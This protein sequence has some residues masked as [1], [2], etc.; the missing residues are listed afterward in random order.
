M[1]ESI[2]KRVNFYMG[3][4]AIGVLFCLIV[5]ATNI[6]IKDLD[7]WLHLKM[8][9]LITRFGYVPDHD[10][11]SCS[12]AGKPWVNHEWLFQ[13]LA[14]Y[15]YSFGGA[16]GLITMQTIV[17]SLTFLLLLFLGYHRDKHLGL[18]FLL[19][20][21]LLVYEFRFTIRPDIFSLL[22]FVIFIYVLA[23]HIDKNWSV[24]ALLTTQILWSNVH[25]F[26]F[27]GPLIICV[28][29]FSETIKR[30]IRLP[31]EWNEVG[32]LTNEEFKRL[33][34]IF[35]I[36]ILACFINPLTFRG[37]WYPI[38]VLLQF[39]HGSQ[40]FFE[41]I[42]ELQ[43]PI[44][45]NWNNIFS[46]NYSYY[47]L[48]IF[49][50]FISFI[51]NRK[52][53]DVG[54][55]FIWTVFLLFSLVAVRNV[56]YFALVAYLVTI[57]NFMSI[58]LDELIPIRFTDRKFLYMTSILFHLLLISWILDY[59][60]KMSERGYYDFDNYQRKSEYG[61]VSKR[62]FPSK[63]ADFLVQTGIQGNFFNDFNSG[64]YLVGRAAPNIKVFIDGRTE[65][66]GAE[67]FERYRSLWKEENTDVLGS[68]LERY[69]IT[70][71]FLN[72][73]YKEVPRKVLR[74]FADHKEWVLVYFDYDG[75]IYLKD[76]SQ[77]TSIINRYRMDFKKIK[78]RKTDLYRLGSILATP[79]RE[80]N[81]AYTLEALGF[82]EAAMEEA[83]HARKMQPGYIEPYKILGKIY[84][85]KGNHEKAFENFRTATMINPQDP[86]ARSNMA[87]ALDH[88]GK[89]DLAV[90][91][92][93]R[94]L[95]DQPSDPKAYFLLS[96]A[97]A[98]VKGYDQLKKTLKTA[99]Q[100]DPKDCADLIKIGDV[101]YEQKD[102][103]I[104]REIYEMGL[105]TNKE[106]A[107]LHQKI[108]L[109]YR[110]SGDEAKALEELRKAIE[111]EPNNEDFKKSLKDSHQ[112]TR[113]SI[114]KN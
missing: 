21:V 26:F 94:L 23:L 93:E 56:V 97:Y 101:L 30:S 104:A 99:R 54:S 88:L 91:Q 90:Q 102:Y 10:I 55:F 16:D 112:A 13:I 32:R 12:I 24:L 51:F 103:K 74:Y 40:I 18:V 87:L 8:G 105:T 113:P 73:V 48:M 14:H 114:N 6:E 42:Q 75:L 65:V 83:N 72:S 41:H 33:K 68:I 77:N 95:K 20:L 67:F 29:L 52:K 44:L 107:K 37:A 111:M 60:Q 78:D 63:A 106:T 50:S 4:F 58:S 35:L 28:A 27:M 49:L 62:S 15:V 109:S 61:G 110:A 96:R 89:Y 108:G 69:H 3:F 85:K 17:V 45:W 100:L 76:I 98:R 11:L 39:P 66:Y 79:Y 34:W 5:F 1:S 86:E 57:T 92:Y 47:K 43:K 38:G 82:D 25:G 59:G 7:L 81:R 46:P 2:W 64:A 36:V 71:A 31:W 19:L 70:G 53:I 22:F 80:V 9:E 84:G